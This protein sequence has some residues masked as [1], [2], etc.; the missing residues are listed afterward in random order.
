MSIHFLTLSYRLTVGINFKPSLHTLSS[1]SVKT[2]S[3]KFIG[4]NISSGKTISFDRASCCNNS[5][6][7]GLNQ[8]DFLRAIL[9]LFLRRLLPVMNKVFLLVIEFFVV[10]AV[11]TSLDCLFLLI[12]VKLS[13]FFRCLFT[14]FLLIRFFSFDKIWSNSE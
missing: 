5:L 12:F 14:D 13:S 6:C 1:S 4:L 10:L 11:L 7:S 3:V 8:F 2:W 9:F